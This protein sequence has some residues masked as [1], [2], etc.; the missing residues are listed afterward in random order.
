[1]DFWDKLE[2]YCTVLNKN[3][4]ELADELGMSKGTI[5]NW[6]ARISQPSAATKKKIAELLNIP[7]SF[8]EDDGDASE[9]EWNTGIAMDD[10]EK[11]LLG[12]YRKLQI[13]DRA[14]LLKYASDLCKNH[15]NGS[16]K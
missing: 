12:Y 9:P 16:K 8:L 2:H 10:Y 14:D 13:G 5:S 15:L 3:Q 6:K 7:V 11:A 1:M 4:S